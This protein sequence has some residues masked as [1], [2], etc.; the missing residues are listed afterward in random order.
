MNPISGTRPARIQPGEIDPDLRASRMIRMDHAGGYG[1]GRIYAGQLAVLGYGGKSDL[2]RDRMAREARHRELFSS[3]VARRRI[4]PTALLPL[5]GVAGFALGAV[6]AS[7]G[8]RAAAACALAVEEATRE[9]YAAQAASLGAGEKELRET[10]EAIRA[11]M[12]GPDDVGSDREAELT[13]AY[14]IL[15]RVI[16]AGC[17][18][19]VAVSEIL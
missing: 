2:L 12:S 18:R 5:W 15:S 3:L 8:E 19:A 17:R 7:L 14:R 9:H 4:R 13:P 10:I 1:A 11:E 6:T 16:K